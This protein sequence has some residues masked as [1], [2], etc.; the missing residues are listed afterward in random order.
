[1][2]DDEPSYSQRPVA[3]AG[4]QRTQTIE[5]EICEAGRRLWQRFPPGMREQIKPFL[6]ST[7]VHM[8]PCAV[9]PSA[10]AAVAHFS[11]QTNYRQW[12]KQWC[13]LHAATE[14]CLSRAALGTLHS[15]SARLV[16]K[17]KY[18][19]TILHARAKAG[20]GWAEISSLSTLGAAGLRQMR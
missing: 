20:G 14:H 6:L 8:K 16:P 12:L 10:R 5:I 15:G 9:R 1:M 18:S 11:V 19:S 13:A 3:A 17:A 4:V 2:I 7:Y